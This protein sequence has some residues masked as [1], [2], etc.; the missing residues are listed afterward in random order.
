MKHSLADKKHGDVVALAKWLQARAFFR[1][2]R[3]DL[4]VNPSQRLTQE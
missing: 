1:V 3:A 2:A 4:R